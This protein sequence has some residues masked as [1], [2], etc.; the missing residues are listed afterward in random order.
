MGPR[1]WIALAS[2][3]LA[4]V[5]IFFTLYGNYSATDTAPGRAANQETTGTI[6]SNPDTANPDA[7]APKQP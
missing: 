4:V 1:R 5:I 7:V 3:A 2:I 6:P